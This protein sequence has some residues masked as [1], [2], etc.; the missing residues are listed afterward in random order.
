MSSRIGHIIGWICAIIVA[1]FN[2]FAAVMKFVPIVP[3]SPAEEM[4][5]KLGMEGLMYPLGV[6]EIIIVVLFLLPRTSTVGF[7]LMIGYMGGALA[8]NL[9][10]GF[11]QAEVIPIYVVFLLL[12]ISA[13]FRNPEL[14]SRLR[15]KPVP[16]KV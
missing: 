2:L 1:A 7:V 13:Y 9:T 4:S 6:L 15:K 14:L 16:A 12:T 3:G 11:S 10:H 5:R 8:T